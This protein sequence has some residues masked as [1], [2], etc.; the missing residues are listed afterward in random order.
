VDQSRPNDED[1]VMRADPPGEDVD[2]HYGALKAACERVVLAAGGE[3]VRPGLI[4]GPHDPTGR[5]SYWPLRL[6]EGGDVLAPGPAEQP[7]QVIDVRDLARWLVERPAGTERVFNA[8]GDEITLGAALETIRAATGGD[9]RLIW[10]EGM[11]D[12]EPW[13][14]MP[15][16]LGPTKGHWGMA[17]ASNA[18]ARAAGLRFRPLAE[19]ARDTLA[20]AQTLTGDPPRQVDGRY[21]VQAL[22][23]E[24]EAQIL[25]RVFASQ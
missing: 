3:V 18:R 10:R 19:T 15:L 11:E 4:V 6:A 21:Q 22:S 7:V 13:S 12:L 14:E 5:F 9:A 23:R 17:Q 16:W 1:S 8:V 24:K 2:L 25:A 20:W